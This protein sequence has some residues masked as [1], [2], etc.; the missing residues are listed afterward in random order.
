MTEMLRF[1]QLGHAV[2]RDLVALQPNE[3][4]LIIADTGTPTGLA[5]AYMAAALQITDDAVLVIER[6]RQITAM[7]LAPPLS[8][9]IAEARVILGLGAGV[10]SRSDACTKAL[11]AGARVLL[12]DPRNM[13]DYLLDGILNVDV[14]LMN[15]RT[16]A[17]ADALGSAS[18]CSITTATGATLKCELTGRAVLVSD[19]RAVTPGEMDYYPGSQVS[20]APIETSIEGRVVVDGSM[21]T[22]GRVHDPFAMTLARGEVQEIAGDGADARR[23][24]D[25]VAEQNDPT[26]SKLCHLSIGLNPKAVISGN[27]YEDERFFGCIDFGFGSQDAKFGG[28]IGLSKHHIDVVS[29]SPTIELDGVTI[30]SDNLLHI[31]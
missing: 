29:S 11:S 2:L 13:I 9:A 30:L 25:H 16:A 22:L 1:S 7:E 28:T 4:V 21:S 19:G 17:L 27:I 8:G 14:D 12:T 26:L 10:F 3:S 20:I 6:Q 5:E 15:R 31:G 18:H 24:R 23:F